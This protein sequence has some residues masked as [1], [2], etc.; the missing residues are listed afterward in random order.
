MFDR[1]GRKRRNHPAAAV[2]RRHQQAARLEPMVGGREAMAPVLR[3][4]RVGEPTMAE[5]CG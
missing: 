2:R 4:L 3:S 5:L 1:P